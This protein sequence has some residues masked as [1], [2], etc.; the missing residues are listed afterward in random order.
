[1]LD[2][3]VSSAVQGVAMLVAALG[4]SV[5]YCIAQFQEDQPV[6]G[7][8]GLLV[9]G[10]VM[11]IVFGT[12]LLLPAWI[13]G[14]ATGWRGVTWAVLAAWLAVLWGAWNAMT[15]SSDFCI[16]SLVAPVPAWVLRDHNWWFPSPSRVDWGVVPPEDLCV[17]EMLQPIETRGFPPPGE[18]P[19]LQARGGTG[20]P[21]IGRDLLG[22]D[23][24]AAWSPG[25]LSQSSAGALEISS[26]IGYVEQQ[27]TVTL[28]T[29]FKKLFASPL[30]P[31]ASQTPYIAEDMSVLQRDRALGAAA[32]E[33]SDTVLRAGYGC[34]MNGSACVGGALDALPPHLAFQFVWAG[35][36]GAR[37]GIHA[38]P[39]PVNILAQ[40]FGEK[41]VWLF[42][43]CDW[44]ELGVSSKFDSG[45]AVAKLDVFSLLSG[46]GP[47]DASVDGGFSQGDECSELNTVRSYPSAE[48]EPLREC[49][50]SRLHVLHARLG[51]GDV[52]FIPQGW[53]HMVRTRTDSVSLSVRP[54]SACEILKSTALMSII[55]LHEAGLYKWGD[56]TCHTN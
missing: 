32:R 23:M 27:D 8:A 47:R 13:V 15:A 49:S 52:L 18:A 56:C 45:A 11:T 50:T 38:D 14:R 6:M 20:R 33:I 19:L 30:G 25:A 24:L 26:Q 43:P 16:D 28:Y 39:D 17:P 48:A 5:H 40:L 54:H 53:A 46:E 3:A 31:D 21:W 37:T 7:L 41:D 51:P 2:W 29:S 35:R 42:H 34:L 44:S 1:M 12:V 9:Q 22:G 36:V 4:E 10:V 55:A